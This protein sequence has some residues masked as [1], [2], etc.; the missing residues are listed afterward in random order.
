[1]GIVS[2]V[3][4]LRSEEQQALCLTSTWLEYAGGYGSHIALRWKPSP[5]GQKNPE[6]HGHATAALDHS[7]FNDKTLLIEYPLCLVR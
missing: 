1:M 3:K 5:G 2:E 4:L 6:A 7:T